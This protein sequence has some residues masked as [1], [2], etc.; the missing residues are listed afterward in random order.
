VKNIS[1][2]TYKH[3]LLPHGYVHNESDRHKIEKVQTHK[4][5]KRN[6]V[7]QKVLAVTSVPIDRRTYVH[8]LPDQ[9]L[10]RDIQ[11]HF[12]VNLPTSLTI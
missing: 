3:E 12:S 7:L 2:L 6:I 10:W 1:K 9:Q 5:W 11:I 4:S 8:I